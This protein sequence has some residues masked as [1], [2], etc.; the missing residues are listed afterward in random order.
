MMHETFSRHRKTYKALLIIAIVT[1]LCSITLTL[2]SVA[3]EAAYQKAKLYNTAIQAET[4]D[5]FNYAVDTE[6]GNIL[7][8][9]TFS[10]VD[11]VTHEDLVG[12]YYAVKKVQERYTMHTETY[13]CGTDEVPM[14]CTRIYHTWDY[15]GSKSIEAS[16]IS[17]HNREYNADIFS[18]IP[19]RRVGCDSIKLECSGGYVYED[20]GWWASVGDLRWYYVVSSK[21]W[22]GTIF[23]TTNDGQIAPVYGDKIGI[24]QKS[25]AEMISDANS[26][27]GIVFGTYFIIILIILTAVIIFKE[28]V[29]DST[30]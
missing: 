16:R 7:T 22:N 30:Q 20:G 9:T 10:A 19:S 23:I 12:E 24:S 14:T 29:I 6:Q 27:G 4:A 8:N 15:N 25:V 13:Q 18:G 26:V 1:I 17:F 11:F 2:G 28:A 5:S 21:E 3:K